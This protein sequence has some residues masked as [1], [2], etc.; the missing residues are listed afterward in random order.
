[1]WQK[2]KNVSTCWHSDRKQLKRAMAKFLSTHYHRGQKHLFPLHRFLVHSL[3]NIVNIDNR[4]TSHCYKYTM[5]TF[6]HLV[7]WTNSGQKHFKW[8]SKCIM[9]PVCWKVFRQVLHSL[10]AAQENLS[11][12]ALSSLRSRA[13]PTPMVKFTVMEKGSP[14]ALPWPFKVIQCFFLPRISLSET[15]VVFLKPPQPDE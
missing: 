13:K 2:K 5:Q 3:Q 8:S 1:M 12:G 6:F 10:A 15:N 9:W 11:S 14:Q 4:G 7:W